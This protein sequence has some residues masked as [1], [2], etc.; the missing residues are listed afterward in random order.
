MSDLL[1]PVPP[2]ERFNLLNDVLFKK[3]FG[4]KGDE[5]QLLALLKPILARTGRDLESIEIL[6]DTA[7]PP[8]ILGG[9]TSLLD[10][11]ARM[12]DG[13]YCNIE[14]QRQN[15]W[16]IERRSLFYWAKEYAASIGSGQTYKQLPDVIAVNILDFTY[17]PP[18]DFHTSF[19]LWEDTHKEFKLTGAMEIHFLEMPKFRRL[20]TKNI[21]A[22]SLH[23]WLS[24]LDV[25]SPIPLIEEIVKM[26]TVIA[27]TKEL[28]ER[29]IQNDA[30]RHA[31]LLQ[32]MAVYDEASRL[33]G[34]REEGQQIGMEKGRKARD[35]EIFE[36]IQKG[37]T[38]EQLKKLLS[39][40]G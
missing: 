34:A 35:K 28:A 13:T 8:E 26:D 21:K 22:N 17:F 23:R 24:F 15:Q 9:K 36:L 25:E 32:E 7:Q 39:S 4:E 38:T 14:V 18:E 11:R 29:F 3:L 6:E 31:Y 20:R 19:H 2:V 33:E 10:L 16:N 27:R 12:M 40:G 1:L 5:P 37:Y 30:I